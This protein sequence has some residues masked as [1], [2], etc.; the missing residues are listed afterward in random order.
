M[1]MCAFNG[2]DTETEISMNRFQ[3]CLNNK[4]MGIDIISGR[5]IAIDE[6]IT[7]APNSLLIIEL[8]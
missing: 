6:K 5:K 8:Q 2:N 4:Q 1:L 3:E 7:M